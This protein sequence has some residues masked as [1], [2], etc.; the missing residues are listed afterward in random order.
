MYFLPLS[1]LG[2]P[3][4]SIFTWRIPR[5][6][7]P[8]GLQSMGLRR[9]RHDWGPPLA[10][11]P[12]H[13]KSPAEGWSPCRPLQSPSEHACPPVLGLQLPSGR[14]SCLLVTCL[15]VPI[16][17]YCF[18]FF[19]CKNT[20]MLAAHLLIKQTFILNTCYLLGL[21]MFAHIAL[22]IFWINVR[23]PGSGML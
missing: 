18:L 13:Q 11:T 8:G 20:L 9:V 21:G 3:H 6:E 22:S 16:I 17:R 15:L 12:T 1:Y 5:I 10:A 19:C 7:E 2:S 4:S 14:I 23:M